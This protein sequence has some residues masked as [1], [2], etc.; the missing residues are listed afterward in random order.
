[1]PA[2]VFHGTADD[3]VPLATTDAF[4]AAHPDRVREVQ[5]AGAN[6]VESWNVDPAG[7]AAR[8]GAFL[9]CVTSGTPAVCTG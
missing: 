4:R 6:H 7:Y 5:V 2:L 9:G 3:T 8:E 1:M